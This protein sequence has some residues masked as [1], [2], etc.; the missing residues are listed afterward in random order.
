MTNAPFAAHRRLPRHR[1]AQP[2]TRE[3][4]RARRRSPQQVL[5]ALRPTSRDNA[6]TPM[7]WDASPH[8]GLHHRHAVD[9]GQPQ[10]HGDQRAGGARDP[11]SV[12]DHRRLI[13][14]RHTEP[15]VAHGDFTMLLPRRRARMLRVHPPA[16]RR[17]AAG[18]RQ[19]L[20]VVGHVG[21]RRLDDAAEV[22][23]GAG[24][25]ACPWEGRVLSAPA[26][27][28]PSQARRRAGI[29][30]RRQ[31][32]VGDDRLDELAG[33]LVGRGARGTVRSAE[34]CSRMSSGTVAS[35]ACR[36]AGAI[37]TMRMPQGARSRAA[38][39]VIPATPPFDAV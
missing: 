35:S 32:R 34:P 4:G 18:A 12:Y 38:G 15:A 7:Q 25:R 24:G 21:D 28:A 9:G 6:R 33:T 29:V 3:R 31:H 20:G 36:R 16:R 5:A 14:L 13:A 30:F 39:S 2:R 10:P 23:I 19:L 22:L 27:A 37:V 11:G 17:R 1:V 8:A 26:S